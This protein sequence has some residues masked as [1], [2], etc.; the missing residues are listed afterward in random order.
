MGLSGLE[1]VA[2]QIWAFPAQPS[3]RPRGR[4]GGKTLQAR[5]PDDINGFS[6]IQT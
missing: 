3:R 5:A 6:A 2:V 1:P 4:V